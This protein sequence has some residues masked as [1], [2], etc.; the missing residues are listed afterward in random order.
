[1]HKFLLV[2]LAAIVVLTPTTS[3]S[4]S[5]SDSNRLEFELNRVNPE[6]AAKWKLGRILTR[7]D[8]RLLKC[9]YDFALQGG[10]ISTVNLVDED[11]KACVV[12]KGA[13]IRDVLI[14]VITA[15]TT[16]TGATMALTAQSAGDLKAALAAASYTG[17]VAGIPVGTTATAIKLTADRT[18]QATIA[19]GTFTA[20][21]WYVLI[22]YILS[23]ST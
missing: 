13:V 19:T 20:G 14:D 16:G 12:P 23:D 21:K 9:K 6:I 15:G 22:E 1:M 18:L 17:L 3:F 4:S 5:L 2:A 7:R 10:A 11:G 8:Q